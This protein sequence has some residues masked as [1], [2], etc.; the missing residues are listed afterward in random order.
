M[1]EVG[2]AGGV[3]RGRLS[4]WGNRPRGQR[5]AGLATIVVGLAGVGAV[6]FAPMQS[7]MG[8]RCTEDA[9]SV[10]CVS[11]PVVS[12]RIPLE[13]SAVVF[14]TVMAVVAVVIGLTAAVG[15]R[16]NRLTKTVLAGGAALWWA[17]TVLSIASI[18]V[19]FIPAGVAAGISAAMEWSRR[20]TN[21]GEPL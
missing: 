15:P 9:G 18:G 7:G 10:T 4:W 2:A 8:A 20:V 5:V 17:G 21:R 12:S 6:M 3:D 1:S 11:A 14:L 16:P 19:L 13:T